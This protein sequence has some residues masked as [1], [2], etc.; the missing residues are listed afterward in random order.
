MIEATSQPARDFSI[1]KGT[2]HLLRS[3]GIVLKFECVTAI[4]N[5]IHCYAPVV[6]YSSGSL[7]ITS[8][9]S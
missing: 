5:G 3:E 7:P 6:T 1:A 2:P 4:C 8:D 9:A